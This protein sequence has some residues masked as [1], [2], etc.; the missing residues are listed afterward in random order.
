[1]VQPAGPEFFMDN[2]SPLILPL[3]IS[4]FPDK[5]KQQIIDLLLILQY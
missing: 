4:Y 5:K 3:T 2:P 1:M